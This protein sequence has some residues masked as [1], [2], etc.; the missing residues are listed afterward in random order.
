MALTIIN[1][2]LTR[3]LLPVSECID[4]METAML[5]AS[6]RTVAVPP[7]MST[8]LGDNSA[9][10]MLMPGSSR[11]L[12]C[13]GAKVI[14]LHPDNPGKDL[15]AIQ[16][17]VVLFDYLTGARLA[18]V[19]GA[20]L[21]A[22]RTAAASGLATR[23]LA[24]E[25]AKSCGIFGTGVQAISH[26]D[27]MCAVRPL[28]K[29]LLWGRNMD[30]TRA[31]AARQ[32]EITGLNILASENPVDVGSC[33]LVC[34]VTASATPV[35]MGDWVQSGA[36]VNLVGSHTLST[37]EADTELVAGSAVYVDL[38]E[39]AINESGDVMIPVQEG[40]LDR[41]HIRGEIGQLLSGEI[42][43]RT[44]PGQI[45]LYKSLGNTAQDLYAA[46]H[47]YK[48]ALELNLGLTADF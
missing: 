6:S 21:T 9:S 8:P 3:Q 39:S 19:E 23:L 46:A 40:R 28:E 22:I 4:V 29:I 43:G 36:H 13:Y 10:L 41:G 33:D 11:E 24:R 45:T 32:A 47:V 16:G 15:P 42:A 17:F 2:A 20:T 30:K 44:D 1:A 12:G 35:L 34:T 27:A 14:G 25:D 38:L 5:A 37:R 26:I 48:K 18:L 31:L 7:R